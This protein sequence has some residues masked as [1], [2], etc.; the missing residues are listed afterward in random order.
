VAAT[1]N[2]QPVWIRIVAL[3]V[4]K[5]RPKQ[6]LSAADRPVVFRGALER[7]IDR[8]L[9]FQEA[10]ARHLA[11]PD[12]EVQAAYEKARLEHPNDDEWEAFLRGRHLTN[13]L[14]RMEI[15]TEK[16]VALLMRQ[17]VQ[18]VAPV[19][20]E[21]A[22]TYFATHPEVFETGERIRARRL[23]IN[24]PLLNEAGRE[25][26]RRKLFPTIRMALKSTDDFETVARR[27]GTEGTYAEAGKPQILRRAELPEPVAEAA[28][29]L[30]AGEMTDF[31]ETSKGFE[32]VKVEERLPSEKLTY[33][34]AAPR[35]RMLLGQQRTEE[36]MQKTIDALRA[37][38]RIERFL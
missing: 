31:I 20:D 6:V 18:S 25:T 37:K 4:Q 29:K 36:S 33:E 11:P 14:F 30:K 24:N 32:M 23:E 17:E 2:G 21:E 1:V 10:L 28:F 38:A 12:A 5:T 19:T 9:L 22:R 34:Q 3:Y 27:Y 7:C 8:E 13:D 26:L 35:L 16:T 15:R